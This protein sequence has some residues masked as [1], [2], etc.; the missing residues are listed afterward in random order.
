MR[1][2]NCAAMVLKAEGKK[3]GEP[4][5]IA[6]P[7]CA[8]ANRVPPDTIRLAEWLAVSAAAA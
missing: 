4:L 3:T 1:C 5:L 7:A 2:A 8:A 6:C